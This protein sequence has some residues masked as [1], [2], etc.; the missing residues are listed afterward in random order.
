MFCVFWVASIVDL[1]GEM[2]NNQDLPPY[3]LH[4]LRSGPS[5][6]EP[7][8]GNRSHVQQPGGHPHQ[9]QYVDPMLSQWWASVADGGSTLGQ[10]I[11]GVY[12]VNIEPTYCGSRLYSTQNTGHQIQET[13]CIVPF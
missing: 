1:S 12:V 10:Y 9:T 13:P 4:T 3:E 11:Y 6:D 7:P 2:D 8:A 5:E